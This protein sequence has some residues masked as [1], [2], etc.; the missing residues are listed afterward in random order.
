VVD[1]GGA[2]IEGTQERCALWMDTERPD[3]GGDRG[4]EAAHQG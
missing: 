4:D 3:T 1:A 2:T